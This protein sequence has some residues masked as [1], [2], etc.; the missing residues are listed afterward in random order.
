MG[1]NV[2]N[3]LSIAGFEDLPMASQVWPRITTYHQPADDLLY[4]ATRLLI[5]NLKNSPTIMKQ[6]TLTGETG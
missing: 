4:E 6:I 2:P 1:I 5:S 3:Q